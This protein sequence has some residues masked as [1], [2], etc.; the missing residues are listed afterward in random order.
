[1]NS[2]TNALTLT[3]ERDVV[4]APSVSAPALLGKQ[5]VRVPGDPTSIRTV[6]ARASVWAAV[7]VWSAAHGSSFSNAATRLMSSGL[8]L[9][10]SSAATDA[11]PH[12]PVVQGTLWRPWRSLRK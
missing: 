12:A 8:A 4:R 2:L 1:M 11:R 3:K 9:A 6:R 7:D 10:A 5:G